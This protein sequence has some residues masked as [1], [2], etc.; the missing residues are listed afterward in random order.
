MTPY[1]YSR[2]RSLGC[3]T[4]S[5]QE[6]LHRRRRLVQLLQ[7]I[8]VPYQPCTSSAPYMSV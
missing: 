5:A 6:P 4:S 3:F 2:S 7:S 8:S 1:R